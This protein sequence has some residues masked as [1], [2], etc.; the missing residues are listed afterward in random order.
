[1]HDSSVNLS[2]CCLYSDWLHDGI[3]NG[4]AREKALREVETISD[5][6]HV[7]RGYHARRLCVVLVQAFMLD[8]AQAS[9][10]VSRCNVARRAFHSDEAFWAVTG[11]ALEQRS[12]HSVNVKSGPSPPVIQH[13]S[14]KTYTLCVV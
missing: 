13:D 7:T 1:M 5:E 14:G 12:Q 6:R 10:Q 2:C 8:S 4:V 9:G 11:Y 3:K